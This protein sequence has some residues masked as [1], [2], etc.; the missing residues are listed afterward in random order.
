MIT[1]IRK[2]YRIYDIALLDLVGS[3]VGGY[4]V[5]NYIGINPYIAAM[6]TIPIGVGVHLMLGVRTKL[7]KVTKMWL[8]IQIMSDTYVGMIIR[9]FLK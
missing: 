1:E 2:N 7:T 5:G 4:A 9:F 6:S 3:L 8:L